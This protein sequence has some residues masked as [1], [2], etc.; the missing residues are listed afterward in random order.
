[1]LDFNLIPA[2][3]RKKKRSTALL[4][5]ILGVLVAG[6]AMAGIAIVLL[7]R[8]ERRTETVAASDIPTVE[9][10]RVIFAETVAAVRKLLVER[11]FAGALTKAEQGLADIERWD[12]TAAYR[13]TLETY[14]ATAE[15]LHANFNRKQ[16]KDS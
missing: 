14:R 13:E 5:G 11:R 16:G 6:I 4:A 15:R 8:E 7:S 3:L 9:E 2:E 10:Q 1:M 12:D